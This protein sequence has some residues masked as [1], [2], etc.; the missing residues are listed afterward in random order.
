MLVYGRRVAD[1]VMVSLATDGFLFGFPLVFN[2]DQVGRYVSTGVGANPAAPFNQFS[3]ARQLAGPRDTFVT[4]NNDTLYSMAQ[5]DL[6]V[7][8][9]RLHV[10]D[11]DGRYYVLQFVD[12][13]TNNF[14]YVGHRATGTA[15]GDFLLVPPGW[16]GDAPADATVIRVPTRVASIVGRWA[17]A[18]DDDLPVVH[19]LARRHAARTRDHLCRAG[20]HPD[21]ER[22][23]ARRS[24]VLGEAATVVASLPA[25]RTRPA[26]AATARR[27][28]RRRHRNLAV[29]RSRPRARRRAP[30]GAATRTPA[31]STR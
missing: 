19:A 31:S 1:D 25:A 4:I 24:R 23:C 27:T 30:T 13:W 14:A 6:S 11:T 22:R 9:V 5:L 26:A 2:L 12:A 21:P 17:C 8:P 29:P 7:G 20:R 10:P 16:T 15:A 3:H 18:G 28:R